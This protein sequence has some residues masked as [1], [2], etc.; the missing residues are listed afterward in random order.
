[1]DLLGWQRR[2]LEQAFTQM[3]EVSVRVSRRGYALVYLHHVYNF[4]RHLF[5]CQGAEHLPRGMAAADRHDETASRRDSGSSLGSDEF[6]SL[7]RHRIGIGKY[8]NLHLK[9]LDS[10]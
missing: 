1:M 8:V 5:V 10:L 7:S 6:R 9:L 3:G 4:P 2:M